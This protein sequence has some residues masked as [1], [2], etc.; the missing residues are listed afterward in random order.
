MTFDGSVEAR[1]KGRR[2]LGWSQSFLDKTEM[3]TNR[4]KGN[5]RKRYGQA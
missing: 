3:K 2:R 1:L 4:N 5:D